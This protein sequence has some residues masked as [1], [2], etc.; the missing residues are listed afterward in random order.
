VLTGDEGDE[1]SFKYHYKYDVEECL[2]LGY[3]SDL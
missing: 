1:Q 2:I 3:G